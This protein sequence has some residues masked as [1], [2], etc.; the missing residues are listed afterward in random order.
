[1]FVNDRS[2]ARRART[3]TDPKQW[4][5][6]IIWL[7]RFVLGSPTGSDPHWT[8]VGFGKALRRSLESEDIGDRTVHRWVYRTDATFAQ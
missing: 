4:H 1:M 6:V 8:F 3:A 5:P 2:D 7:P